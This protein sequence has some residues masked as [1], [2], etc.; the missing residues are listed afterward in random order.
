MN[1]I[2]K[3]LTL[4]ALVL[5]GTAVSAQDVRTLETKVADL[6]AR[7]PADN[8]ALASRLMEDMYALGD[9]GRAMICEQIV[10]AGKGD[11][12]RAR[13]AVASLT[14][15]LSKD[16]DDTRKG[17]WESQCIQFMKS[18]G[19]REVRSFFMRQLSLTGSDMAVTAL[20]DYV[21][22]P[23]ICDDAVIVLQSIGS[24]AAAS[25][26]YSSLSEVECP[27]AAQVMV[28]LAAT[29]PGSATDIYMKR[30]LGGNDAE[31]AAALLAI[32]ST[33]APE[34]YDILVDAAR[35]A[36]FRRDP[37]GAVRALLL[38]AKI[39]GLNGEVK[40]ME[41]IVNQVI[42]ASRDQEAASQRL[43]AMS[44]IT[45]VKGSDALGM[46]LEVADDPDVAIRGG[47]L[48]LAAGMPGSDV[49]KKWINRY[50][51]VSDV[52]KP[53]ILFMLGERGDE[54]AVPL[55][56]KALDDP[57]P[58]ISAGAVAALARLQGVRAVDPLI[59]WILKYDNDEGHRAAATALTTIL[60]S[61]GMRK[62][63]AS[64]PGSK[65][66]STVTLIRLLAWSGE[67][68]YFREVL[69][70]TGSDDIAIR[71]AA[72]SALQAL[73]SYD[74]QKE[75]IALLDAT[76]D[77]AEV[78]E[79]QR[80]LLNAAM[81]GDTPAIRSALILQALDSSRDRLKLIPLLAGTGGEEALKRVAAEF[82]NG[83]AITRDVCFDAL[84]HW[85]DHSAA[86]ALISITASGN[87]T[88]GRPAFDAYMRMVSVAP[89]PPERKLL[90]IKEIAPY[91]VAPDARAG[92]VAFAASLGVRQVEFFIAPYLSDPA[93][94]VRNA[95]LEALESL[96][97]PE[98]EEIEQK[99]NGKDLTG[100]QDLVDNPLTSAGMIPKELAAKEKEAGFVAL[101][102]GKN[103]DGWIGNKVSYV[104]EEG[105]IV[106]RPGDGSG[107]NLYTEKE[108]SD[109]VFRFEFQLTPGANNGLGI[110][111]PL[112][113]DAAYVGMEL[114]ILDN[115]AS[116][117]ANLKPYQYHGSVYGVIPA[118]RGF[119]RPVGEWNYQEV[120]VQGTKVKVVLNGTVIVDGDIAGAIANGTMD[121]KEHPGLSNSRGHIGFLGHG[122]VVKFRNIRIREL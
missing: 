100:W 68:S 91:A 12:L 48:R 97:L 17:A 84:S 35:A 41:R 15:H 32:A 61:T 86:G 73:A 82:E 14:A 98:D 88:F 51:R 11:D 34:A 62:I 113:G 72:I 24:K 31:K 76:S 102:N 65:G 38:Y 53:E 9:E 107:G 36:S 54:L 83:D 93:E 81:Q 16:S 8:L 56:M 59:S 78:T 89:L 60:D 67:K 115:T 58:E 105:M 77:R 120:T 25:L 2:K 114:Q 80:A 108:Y 75:I 23:E 29:H 50:A 71:A 42:D 28:A 106:I 74:D 121:Q 104:A 47:A 26:L 21:S 10:P 101:F 5:I 1:K 43:A 95:A 37:G 40:K 119:L 110:R 18:A 69:P 66:N 55:M 46:L 13:Y 92:M 122:S 79:L 112:E 57:S 30:Y 33:G 94:E 116:I 49:T 99:F 45:G 64:L 87:K 85:S 90:M 103:L 6:L 52:A 117:Y 109:F 118:R 22:S 27:C 111:T 70:L 4:T 63:A 19:D 7:M 39:I 20:S 96:K 44:I 3:L